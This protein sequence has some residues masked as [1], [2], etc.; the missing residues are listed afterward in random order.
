MHAYLKETCEAVLN[1][2]PALVLSPERIAEWHS[3]RQDRGE[4]AV[5]GKVKQAL[6]VVFTASE[7]EALSTFYES[8]IG[9]YIKALTPQ[10]RRMLEERM[11]GLKDDAEKRSQPLATDY[12]ARIKA[13]S[14]K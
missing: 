1:K 8:P 9:K 4:K 11:G 3:I 14:S 13:A 5:E 10:A 2:V 12:R 6:G 7:M